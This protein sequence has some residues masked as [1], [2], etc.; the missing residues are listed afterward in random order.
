MKKV[1]Y[2]IH[3]IDTVGTIEDNIISLSQIIKKINL[4]YPNVI[5]FCPYF[6]DVSILDMSNKEQLN[7]AGN[8]DIE[9]CNRMQFDE[10]WVVGEYHMKKQ[11]QIMMSMAVQF[12]VP[13]VD[14]VN[15]I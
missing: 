10:I 2:L 5:P 8:N 13:V 11:K 7:R 4:N 1:V 3:P 6:A 15:K 14:M 12:S 9:V